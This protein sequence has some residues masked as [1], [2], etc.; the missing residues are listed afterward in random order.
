MEVDTLIREVE[1]LPKAAEV[2]I[3]GAGVIGCSTAYHLARMGITDIAVFEMGQVGSGSSGKSASML[4]LQFCHDEISVRMAK[5]SYGKYM[6]FEEEIGTPI[7]FKKNGWL[8]LA[9]QERAQDLRRSAELL[10]SLDVRTEILEPEEIKRRYPEIYTEDLV[11][12]TLGEDDG[13]FDPHMIMWGYLKRASETGVRLYQGVHATG[14]EVRHGK[15]EGVYTNKGEVSTK[16]VVNAGGP[17]AVEIGRW[18]DVDIPILNLA[19]GI[20]VTGP[21]PEI[22]SSRPFVEDMSAE[23]YY[24]PEGA[25]VLMGMGKKPVDELD[26]KMTY[27]MMEEIIEAGIH[28]VPVLEKASVLTSWA[29]IRPM[30]SDNHP[31]L[32][33][34]PSLD[35]FIL[36]CGW[37]G[38][39]IVQAPIA[40]QLVA[41]CIS[42]GH[43]TTMDISSLGINRFGKQRHLEG[44]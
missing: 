36:N 13:P 5:Y 4:T 23:W 30:T 7:D 44:N 9:T 31:I 17:W 15:V 34:V 12:G 37:G 24:R 39:G 11:L 40:G 38:T 19:R 25:G 10:Q 2:V 43:T 28:R 1:F 22:P 42:H 27:E 21:F 20:L 33:P 14:I 3:I 41:E 18:L 26:V 8:S 29:G 16:V 6:Q 32:G 35:G